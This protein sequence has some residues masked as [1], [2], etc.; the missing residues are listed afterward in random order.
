MD[1]QMKNRQTDTLT[2]IYPQT[3]WGEGYK[4]LKEFESVQNKKSVTT[5]LV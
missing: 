3:K 4:K 1:G 2:P 5:H